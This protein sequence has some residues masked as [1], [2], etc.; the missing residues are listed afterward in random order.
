[1]VPCAFIPST[2]SIGKIA[3]V[4]EKGRGEA[5]REGYGKRGKKGK[6]E[7]RKKLLLLFKKLKD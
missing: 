4:K 1:M 7:E 6:E 5:G 2:W 3:E